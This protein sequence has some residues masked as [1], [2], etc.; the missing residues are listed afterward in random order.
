[1]AVQDAPAPSFTYTPAPAPEPTPAA[2]ADDDESLTPGNPQPEEV[3]PNDLEIP[4]FL[5]RQNF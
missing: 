5:R 3:E 4:A 1:V 2:S